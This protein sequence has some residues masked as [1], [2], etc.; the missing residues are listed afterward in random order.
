MREGRAALVRDNEQPYH[1][2]RKNHFT[3]Y[4]SSLD[5]EDMEGNE[6]E[7]GRNRVTNINVHDRKVDRIECKRI[8]ETPDISIPDIPPFSRLCV[9]YGTSC[10]AC[11]S[12]LL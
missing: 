12:Y 6:D 3:R 7:L 4:C 9:D 11:V 5:W 8:K 2:K 10:N 1:H